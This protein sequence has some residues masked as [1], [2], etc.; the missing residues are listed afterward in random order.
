[1]EKLYPVIAPN[2][3]FGS[4]HSISISVQRLT[5]PRQLPRGP[6]MRLVSGRLSQTPGGGPGSLP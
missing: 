5:C 4:D 1:V 3:P 6:A 2:L